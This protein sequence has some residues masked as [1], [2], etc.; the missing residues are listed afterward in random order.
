[1]NDIK[2]ASPW[3]TGTKWGI[4]GGLT[5]VLVTYLAG[6]N[7]DWTDM[8]SV[9]GSKN[10]PIQYFSYIVM[11]TLVVL[12]QLEH[13][14]KE[15]GGY[16][17]YARGIGMATIVGLIAGICMAM[18]M[19]VFFGIL[20]PEFQ[21]MIMDTAISK[22]DENVGPEEEAMAIKMINLTTGPGAMATFTLL[23]NVFI[24]LIS[25]IIVSFFTQK[26]NPAA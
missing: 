19:Y 15:L 14:K 7:V 9:E 4:I 24:G 22:M 8:E 6:M 25:G 23:G 21:Q 26:V 10:S 16:M 1:M 2:S 12:A 5:V 13:R 3:P 17:S 18:Y 20:H 11:I